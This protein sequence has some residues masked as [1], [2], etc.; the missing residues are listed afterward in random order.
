[1]TKMRL[2]GKREIGV[3]RS[4]ALSLLPLSPTLDDK[5]ATIARNMQTAIAVETTEV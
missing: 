2:G 1:M 3:R 5:K 4:F